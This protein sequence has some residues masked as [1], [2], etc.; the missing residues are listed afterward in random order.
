V[1]STTNCRNRINRGDFRKQLLETTLSNSDRTDSCSAASQVSVWRG[2]FTF[3]EGTGNP[4]KRAF[5][6]FGHCSTTDTLAKSRIFVLSVHHLY[7]AIRKSLWGRSRRK[8]T[9]TVVTHSPFAGC[10]PRETFRFRL[11][12]GRAVIRW[13]IRSSP[14][15]GDHFQPQDRLAFALG[16]ERT[17]NRSCF[18]SSAKLRRE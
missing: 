15:S 12:A 9:A 8:I 13:P 6:Q 3:A 1:D 7:A 18:S 17:A 2:V 5:Y 4:A 10:F 14:F 11:H 16:F